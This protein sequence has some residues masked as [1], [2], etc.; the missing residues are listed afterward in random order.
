MSDGQRDR[1]PHLLELT[2]TPWP[3]PPL[4]LFVTSGYE[5]GVVH[6]KWDDPSQL[7]LNSAF[8][9]LGVNVWRSFDSE[10]GPYERISE[11]PIG[12]TFWIDQ[13]DNELVVEEDVSDKFILRG[14]DSS[15][16]DAPRFVF[17]TLNQPIVKEGSQATPAN[18]AVDVRVFIDGV[19]ARVQSVYGPTGEVEIDANR[20]PDVARQR[21]IEPVLPSES[22]VVTCTYRYNREMVRTDL[23]QRIFYRVTTVGL[24]VHSNPALVLPTDLIETPLEHAAATNS[25]ELEKLDYIWRE[26]IRRNHWI[27][28]Q[29][30]ERVKI[31]LRKQ[32]GLRCPCYSYTH[33][34]PLGD[35]EICYA[36]GIVGGYEGPYDSII[37]PS[38][39]EKKISQ[40]DR[41]RTV[42]QT[43]EVW[44]G[45]TPLLSQRDFLVKI[46]GDRFSLGGVRIP[47]NRGAVLQ[48]H[49]TIGHLDEK[50]IQYRVPV[51]NPTKFIASQFTNS[52]PEYQAEA[53]TTDSPGI[54][55]ERQIR[56][57]STTWGN[58]NY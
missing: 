53:E 9:I 14:P 5:R 4:N 49:F 20:Y 38:D 46:N 50:A 57:R 15:G 45:P 39:S 48:Q 36:T 58:I 54:A 2:K 6:L 55:A 24:P 25:Y 3:A 22:S 13:T 42:I 28:Q 40:T 10:Y 7:V 44:M 43:D 8:Q 32:V 41:G 18:S 17:R 35:C 52:G 11:L 34:H 31:F 29:G 56:G 12:S 33:K 1:T 16:R 21:W 26:A 51:G 19:E 27:L 23:Y 47:T 37:A 30:G